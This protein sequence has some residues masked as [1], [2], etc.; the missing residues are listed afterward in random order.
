MNCDS[1]LP[2][3]ITKS[4]SFPGSSE[5]TRSWIAIARAVYVEENAKKQYYATLLG[6]VTPLRGENL[7]RTRTTNWQPK[8][9]RKVWDY[10]E[11]KARQDGRL[12]D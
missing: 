3:Q 4:A 5:P 9:A 11:Q 6:P 7:E 1:G 12:P 2:L 10:Y 8:I